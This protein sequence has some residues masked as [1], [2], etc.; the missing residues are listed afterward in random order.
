MAVAEPAAA[1][2]AALRA[3]DRDAAERLARAALARTPGQPAALQILGALASDRGDWPAAI[4]CFARALDADP[5]NLAARYNHAEALRQ[6]GDVPAAVAAFDRLLDAAPGHVPAL[7]TLARLLTGGE[8]QQEAIGLLDRAVSLAPKDARARAARGNARLAAGRPDGIEDLKAACTLAPGSA[9]TWLALGRAVAAVGDHEPADRALAKAVALEPRLAA[10]HLERSKLAMLRG[11]PAAAATH[12]RAAA[13]LASDAAEPRALLARA[14]HELGLDKQAA[15]NVDQALALD[16]RNATARLVQSAL[17]RAAGDDHGARQ[18]LTALL[19]GAPSDHVAVEA[20]TEL[21]HT[22]DRLGDYRAAFASFAEANAMLLRAAP[23]SPA[24]IAALPARIAAMRDLVAREPADPRPATD[25]AD[26]WVDPVFV[27]GF[28][29]SGTALAEQLLAN[30]DSFVISDE[31]PMIGRLARTLGQ[32]YPAT[33]PNLDSARLAELRADYWRE[34]EA[35]FPALAPGKRFVDRQPWNLVELP[36]I[37]RMFPRA[38][39]V[40]MIRDPRDACLSAFMQYFALD[41]ATVHLLTLD[42]A[43]ALYAQM[44]ALWAGLR[45]RLALPVLELRYEELVRDLDA[46]SRRLVAFLDHAVGAPGQEEESAPITDKAVGR[47][48]PYQA[49]LAAVLP[50]LAPFVARFGYPEE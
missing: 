26:P 20:L 48:R 42:G 40:V 1:A 32:D 13:D 36:L 15:R 9:A 50:T 6:A 16:P 38:R 7:V 34:A 49:E 18:A 2:T 33:L 4:E 47:W 28:P 31:A 39:V 3:G 35:R 12:A 27:V 30:H 43:A 44:M 23:F 8:R 24:E 29:R 25:A 19:A 11:D 17:R 41:P 14:L 37:A 22:L 45:T 21:G 5:G 46:A 10:A